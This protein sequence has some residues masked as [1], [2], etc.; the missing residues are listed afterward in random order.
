MRKTDRSMVMA[1]AVLAAVGLLSLGGTRPAAAA[2]PGQ[3][4]RLAPRSGE[5]EHAPLL[6]TG[7]RGPGH[8]PAQPE[9][10]LD[11]LEAPFVVM[12]A[13]QHDDDC[14]GGGQIEQRSVGDPF[15]FGWR[16]RRVEDIAGDEYDVAS[17][18]CAASL[19]DVIEGRELGAASHERCWWRLDAG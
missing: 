6:G 9:Q 10:R 5:L 7:E 2:F 1:V 12:V 17:D 15:C 11:G 19:D 18:A 3:N 8:D 13:G 14:T 4:G 16:R